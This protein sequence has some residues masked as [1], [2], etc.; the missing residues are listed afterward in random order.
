MTKIT[1]E[2]FETLVFVERAFSKAIM[3]KHYG[4]SIAEAHK[5]FSKHST[6]KEKFEIVAARTKYEFNR[7]ASYDVRAAYLVDYCN[8][9]VPPL[10]RVLGDAELI[11]ALPPVAKTKEMADL[12][13]K[14]GG[15]HIAALI[16]KTL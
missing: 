14:L 8:K 3:G 4:G 1:K 16:R 6:A 7:A 2:Q 12:T 11:E 15:K 10:T 9:T 5:V 13:E